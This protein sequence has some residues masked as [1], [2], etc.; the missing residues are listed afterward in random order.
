MES[1]SKIGVICRG[2]YEYIPD[3]DG[4]VYVDGGISFVNDELELAPVI[5]AEWLEAPFESIWPGDLNENGEFIT[6]TYMAWKC[7]RCGR[8]ITESK[9]PNKEPYC[10]CGAKMSNYEEK[11]DD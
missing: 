9:H 10:H 8:E 2:T 1:N 6:H 4:I 3:S 11:T 5:H 7:S